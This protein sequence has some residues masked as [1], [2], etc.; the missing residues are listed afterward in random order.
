[1]LTCRFV[2]IRKL[3]CCADEHIAHSN[4]DIKTQH[5]HTYQLCSTKQQPGNGLISHT[6]VLKIRQMHRTAPG[7]VWPDLG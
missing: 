3:M 6:N 7:I 1:M 5:P 2:T 4:S